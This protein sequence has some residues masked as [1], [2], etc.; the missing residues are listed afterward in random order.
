M[1]VEFGFVLEINLENNLGGKFC[2]E[3][4]VLSEQG[5]IGFEIDFGKEKDSSWF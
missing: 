1:Q 3:F 2:F 5:R 4:D